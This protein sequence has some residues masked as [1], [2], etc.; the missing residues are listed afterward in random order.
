[1][2]IIE[3]QQELFYSTIVMQIFKV[4]SASIIFNIIKNQE[5]YYCLIIVKEG[6]RIAQLVIERIYTPDVIEVDDLGETERGVLGYGSTG[7]Q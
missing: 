1:M 3:V 5:S 4:Y 2:L 7:L 6:D